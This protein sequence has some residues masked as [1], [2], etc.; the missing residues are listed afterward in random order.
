MIQNEN[1]F[2]TSK[3]CSQEQTS[4]LINLVSAKEFALK[5]K[6]EKLVTLQ[7]YIKGLAMKVL[8]MMKETKNVGSLT[9]DFWLL[10]K[11]QLFSCCSNV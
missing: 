1:Q 3:E 7:E 11:Q 5:Q 4:Y 6:L 8:T 10:L 2:N 9:K